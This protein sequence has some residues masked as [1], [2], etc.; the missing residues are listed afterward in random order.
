MS[1]KGECWRCDAKTTR[2]RLDGR[3]ECAECGRAISK[4]RQ[5]ETRSADQ[6]G[7]EAFDA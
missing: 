3:H 2:T 1:E 4:Q 6:H 7:L 5:K